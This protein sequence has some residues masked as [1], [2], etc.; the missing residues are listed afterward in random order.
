MWVRLSSFNDLCKASLNSIFSSLSLSVISQSCTV[1][2]YHCQ[3][4]V[5]ADTATKS[6]VTD[7]L[8]DLVY[9]AV[10]YPTHNGTDKG[11]LEVLGALVRSEHTVGAD[12]N[13][14]ETSHIKD[15]GVHMFKGLSPFRKYPSISRYRRHSISQRSPFSVSSVTYFSSV[16]SNSIFLSIAMPKGFSLL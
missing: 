16:R 4:D 8:L 7:E 13:A 11:S 14:V 9:F 3:G 15:T 1:F 5:V 12:E 2:Q 10:K 6:E